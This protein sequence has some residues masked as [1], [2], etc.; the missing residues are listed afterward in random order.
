VLRRLLVDVPL[1]CFGVV[2]RHVNIYIHIHC[3]FIFISMYFYTCIHSVN[4][5]ISILHES[6]C[7][8]SLCFIALSSICCCVYHTQTHINE[9]I[10]IMHIYIQ[11][12]IHIHSCLNVCTYTTI[13]TY[14]H[15][16]IYK[17]T[18][19]YIYVYIY[20]DPMPAYVAS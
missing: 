2:Y 20:K 16:Y 17:C 5:Y 3:I 6:V 1:I 10:H 4:M 7:D 12:Y 11:I 14:V 15:I 13:H 8:S 19:R 18:Y 9:Y